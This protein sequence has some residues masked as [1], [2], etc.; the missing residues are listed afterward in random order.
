M[1]SPG[2]RALAA[3][4]IALA[5][6]IA[7]CGGSGGDSSSEEPTL[8]KKQYVQKAD[9]ICTRLS[10]KLVRG[11]E[12]FSKEHHLNTAAPDQHERERL[13]LAVTLPNVEE[14]LEELKRLP[15]P[16]GDEAKLEAI[17]A[18]MEHGIESAEK[19]PSWSAAPSP[20]HPEPFFD[21]IEMTADYGIWLCGQA[22]G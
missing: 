13:I 3:L 12:A 1:G 22:G 16:K 14:K 6:A 5:L 2:K 11:Y 20:A 10:H 9:A 15:V 17:F 21:T 7:G 4:G 19:H 8:T 18:S